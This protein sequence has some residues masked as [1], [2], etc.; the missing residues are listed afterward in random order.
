[1]CLCFLFFLSV[2]WGGRAALTLKMPRRSTDYG[3]LPEYE[4]SQ[5]KRTLEL[6]TVMTVYNLKK[7]NPE[8]RTIQVI[9]ETRQVA[10]SKTADKI[11]G[12]CEYLLKGSSLNVS[13]RS[14]AGHVWMDCLI[15]WQA[16]KCSFIFS[17]SNNLPGI[18]LLLLYWKKFL[19]LAMHSLNSFF[20]HLLSAY[21]SFARVCAWLCFPYLS[22]CPLLN[23]L[24]WRNLFLFSCFL[25]M[26]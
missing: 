8:R 4:K 11:E 10:W 18:F 1:M 22:K 2:C 9:M 5:I 26:T 17:W 24:E 16:W 3:E 12:V 13:C 20:T 7:S 21:M 19:F 25:T 6:G 14:I 23:L 15:W